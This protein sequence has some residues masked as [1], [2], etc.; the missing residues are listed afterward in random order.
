MFSLTEEMLVLPKISSSVCLGAQNGCLPVL[1]WQVSLGTTQGSH[2][3]S[4]P[5]W[6][7]PLGMGFYPGIRKSTIKA[8]NQLSRSLFLN[9]G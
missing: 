9:V 4:S 8:A 3:A 2:S 1:G 6:L 5:E 7:L